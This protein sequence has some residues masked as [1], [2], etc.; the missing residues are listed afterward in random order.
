MKRLAWVVALSCGLA[1]AGLAGCVDR[2]PGPPG[3]KVAPGYANQHLL[4]AVPAGITRFDVPLA[5]GKVIYLGNTLATPRVAP[6]GTVT[7]THYW[8]VTAPIGGAWKPFALVRGPAQSA[9]FMNLDATDMEYVH[10]P[11]T[12]AAGEIIEDVQTFTVRP[13]W[14]ATTATLAVGLIATG[15]HDTLDRMPVPNGPRVVDRAI[16][17]ATLDIDLS[18]APPPP[19]VVNIPRARGAIVIDGLANDPGWVGAAESGEFVTGESSG[20]PQGAATA[21][22]VWD[23][24]ALYLFVSVKDPDV[25]SPFKQHDDSLWQADAVEIFIDADRN[26]KGYVELQVNPNNAT[27]D[28]WFAVGRA[29]AKPAW[30]SGMVTAVQVK[31]TPDQSD[32]TDTGWDVEIAIPWATVKGD[33]PAMAVRIPPAVGDQWRLNVV[34]VDKRAGNDGTTVS[35]WNRITIG[36]FHALDRMLTAVFADAT[37]AVRTAPPAPMSAPVPAPMPVPVPTAPAPAATTT[38]MAP[39]PVVP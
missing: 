16:V 10:G 28:S 3:R 24:T 20:E 22:L 32:G 35:S 25:Y 12:W 27:F 11:S 33:D 29:S 21:K 14:K 38:P 19:G 26:G 7:V 30:T 8:R 39:A 2:G 31:G 13:D 17:A 15:K 4:R 23:D 18:H 37:G 34:R 9:D 1:G 6:G 36:D 5:G